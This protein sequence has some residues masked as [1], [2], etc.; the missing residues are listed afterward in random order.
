MKNFL[1]EKRVT[2]YSMT[3]K[4][5]G[6]TLWNSL[7]LTGQSGN[8]TVQRLSGTRAIL[9]DFELSKRSG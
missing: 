9:S 1:G 3:D 7:I 5:L 4:A 2:F 6:N 8:F